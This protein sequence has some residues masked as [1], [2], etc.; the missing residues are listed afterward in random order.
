MEA[1][2]T[3]DVIRS[4][5]VDA[6]AIELESGAMVDHFTIVRLLGRGGMADVYLATDAHSGRDV[7]LK[8]VHAEHTHDLAARFERE[9]RAS[10]R[11]AHPRIVAILHVGVFE[12]RPYA[13]LKHV[14]GTTLAGRIAQRALTPIEAVHVLQ[15]IADAVAHAHARGVYHRDLNPSNVMLDA[16][17]AVQVL[18]F[19]LAKLVDPDKV[20]GDPAGGDRLSIN[21]LEDARGDTAGTPRYMAPEQ[22]DG[23]EVGAPADV[24][25]L[26]VLSYEMIIQRTPFDADTMLALAGEICGPDPVRPLHEIAKVPRSLSELTS[27]CLQ[28]RAS[29]RPSVDDVVEELERIERELLGNDMS[30]D[31]IELP[32]ARAPVIA[33]T[34]LLLFAL[35]A[36]VWLTQ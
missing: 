25:A 23:H 11:M 16:H 10:S 29:L 32:R 3:S 34:V 15:Q 35:A 17:G 28:K 4:R 36:V 19:G 1:G 26:G 18:D 30:P 6:R 14:E 7:A 9:A 12:G 22:W 27:R 13:A 31:T 33:L 20:L 2:A 24:W 21:G 8:L 5:A